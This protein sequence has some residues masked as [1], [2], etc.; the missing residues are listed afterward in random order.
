M[1]SA[2]CQSSLRHMQYLDK[3]DT[4]LKLALQV[5]NTSMW[6]WNILTGRV[7]WSENFE[8]L[9]GVAPGTL[10]GTYRGLLERI[11]QADRRSV[12]QAIARAIR[13]QANYN[14]EFRICCPDGSIRWLE[15]QGEVYCDESSHPV[16]MTGLYW[17]ITLDKQP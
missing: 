6:E 7:V 5:T 9:F 16:K 8:Q 10:E 14:L 1:P 2:N 15:S 17:D 13:E 4:R 12:T 3:S 11:V